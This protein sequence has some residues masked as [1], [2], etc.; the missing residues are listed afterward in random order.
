MGRV[1]SLLLIVLGLLTGLS[2]PM[3]TKQAAAQGEVVVYVVPFTDT[4]DQGL[5]G[6][7][8]RGIGLAE[9]NGARAVI[10]EMDTPGGFIDAATQIKKAVLEA[11]VPVIT[12]VKNHAY[13]AGSLIAL[14]SDIVAMVPGSDIGAAEPRIGLDMRP[15]DPK[16][17]AAWRSE[18]ESVAE[19]RKRNPEIA[20]AMVDPKMTIKGLTQPGR[21]LSLTAVKAVELGVADFMVK[22][23]A[24][25]LTK[26]GYANAQVEELSPGPADALSRLV[27][28]PYVSPLLLLIGLAGL[29]LE[30]FA[31]GFGVAG[32]AGLLALGLF[33]GGHMLAGFTGWEAVL[34]FLL[35]MIA[36]VL[37]IFFIPGHGLAGIAGF[38]LVV[39]SIF[40]ASVSYTQAII[41]LVVA[42]VGSIVVLAIGMKLMTTRNIWNRLILGE[43][44]QNQAGYTAPS[45]ELL[46]F[47]GQQGIS[48]TPLRPAGT[49]LFGNRRQDVVTE[50]SFI[51]TNRPVEV[52]AV[53]GTR[54]IV[55]EVI[56]LPGKRI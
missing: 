31:V 42:L 29:L 18:M 41:S 52:L 36:L 43:Q 17:M 32:I 1:I 23:R 14:A 26:L 16:I 6:F 13:S 15:V 3:L 40:L 38:S 47:V 51:P 44:Q 10:L 21:P 25:L 9:K 54:V 11:R 50:G 37:E 5:V 20:A 24:E 30:A 53:E 2:N 48:I 35:G 22:D 28:N 7:V 19:A 46:Q 12:L 4:I 39:W 49:A 56:K 8:K 34:V 27:T 55:R 33:F 45:R